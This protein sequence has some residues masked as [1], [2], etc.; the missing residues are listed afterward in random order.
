MIVLLREPA[1]PEQAARMLEDWK[2]L[3]KVVVDARRGVLVGGGEMHVDGLALL[4]VEGGRRED[5]WGA[6]WYVDSREAMLEALVNVKPRHGNAWLRIE[7]RE[8]RQRVESL[9][10]RLLEDRGGGAAT[11]EGPVGPAAR[12]RPGGRERFLREAVPGRLTGIATALARAASVAPHAGHAGHAASAA[13]L[14]DDA[15]HFIEWTGAELDPASTAELVDLQIALTLWLRTWDAAMTDPVRRALLAHEARR[16]SDRV[17][18]L[19]AV[20][21]AAAP[22]ASTAGAGSSAAGRRVPG[23]RGASGERA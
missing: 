12:D 1:T 2:V 19:A 17:G 9:V 5:L 22:L 10:R 23:A 11:A 15:R 3:V 4:L 7:N 18:D 13:G 8:E 16:W 6:T 14:I 20:A 21:Q